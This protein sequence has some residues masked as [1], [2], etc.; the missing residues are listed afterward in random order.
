MCYDLHFLQLNFE[1]ECMQILKGAESNMKMLKCS[2]PRFVKGK[3]GISQRLGSIT[4]L[5]LCAMKHFRVLLHQY[6]SQ[7]LN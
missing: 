6:T 4:H 1:L 5:S 2:G 3:G 7:F